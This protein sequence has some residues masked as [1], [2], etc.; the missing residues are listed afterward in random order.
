[1]IAALAKAGQALDEPAY[2]A[3]AERAAGFV[4][5]ELRGPDGR[6][7][8]RWR[9]GAAGLAAHLEDYAFLTWGLIDL[10]EATFKVEYLREALALNDATLEHFWD[11]AGGGGFFM[12]ADDSEQL[13]VRAKKSYGGAIPSGNAVAALN[14][15]RLSRLTGNTEYQDRYDELLRAF[16]GDIS[17]SPSAFPQFLIAIDFATGPSKE[18]VVA[19]KAGGDDVARMLAAIRRPFLPNKVIVLRPDTDVGATPPVSELAPYT[20]EQ[21]SL[22][23]VATAYVC[24]NFTC[25]LPTT[26]IRKVL[27]MLEQGKE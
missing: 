6:L 17:R 21:K 24:E 9:N 23:G 1:M 14:L 25:Q 15:L 4:L 13:L 5:R 20:R 11:E 16:S 7:L 10:Y 19:G 26:D 2:T 22:D 18:I 12:T 8:K 27:E 3:A